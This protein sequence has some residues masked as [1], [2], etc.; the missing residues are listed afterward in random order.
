MKKLA[1]MLLLGCRMMPGAYQYYLYDNS[2]GPGPW[3][4]I[5]NVT[6][7]PMGLYGG[8]L[9]STVPVPD[10]TNEYEVKSELR[11]WY[12]G[13]TYTHYLRANANLTT[14]YSV[15]LTS[16][17]V[18]SVNCTATLNVRKVVNSVVTLLSSSA[19][20]CRDGIAMRSVYTAGQILVYLDNVY[21]GG[22][23]D[24]SIT[25]GQPGVGVTPQFYEFGL[26]ATVYLG[27]LDR[28]APSPV[29]TQ[30]IAASSFATKADVQWAGAIDGANGIGIFGYRIFRDGVYLGER[31]TPAFSDETLSPNTTYTYS[32]YATD[33]HFNQSSAVTFAVTTTPP[34]T[35]DARRVGVRTSGAYWGGLGE[36]IDMASGNLNYSVP[37]LKAMGRGWS[38]PFL[39]SYNSQL[40]RQEGT[41]T[42]KLGQDVGYGFGWRMMA[43]SVMPVY[44][45]YW[46]L[47]HYVFTDA[48][49]AEYRLD[50]NTN[51]V[52]T[53]RDSTYISYDTNL[54]RVYFT[55]GSHWEM[56]AQSA[57]TED[58]AGTRYPTIMQDSNGN[59]VLVRYKTGVNAGWG[60]S[61]AR[62]DEIEDVRATT[63]PFQPIHYKTYTFTYTTEAVPHLTSYMNWIGTSEGS[64]FTYSTVSLASPFNSASFGTTP[65][66]QTMRNTGLNVTTNFEYATGAGELTKVTYP[67]GG[68]QRWEY[69]AFTY[70]GNRSLREVQNRYLL[71]AVGAAE[72]TYQMPRA[73][74]DSGLSAHSAGTV[75]DPSGARKDW[76][77]RTDA[78]GPGQVL[79][80]QERGSTGGSV[81]RQQ[82]FTWTADATGRPYV[83]AVVAALDGVQSKSEQTLDGYG[84]VTVSKQYD[85]GNLTTPSRTYTNTYLTASY[86]TS[87]YM[88]NRLL[89]STVTGAGQTMTLATNT[90][91]GTAIPGGGGAVRQWVSV[92]P[93]YRGNLSRVVKPGSIANVYVNAQGMTPKTTDDSGHEINVSMGYNGAV[94]AAI[95]GG[96]L[97]MSMSYNS[98]LGLTQETGSNGE[99]AAIGYDSVGRPTQTTS[100]TGAGTSIEYTNS[101]PTTK[102]TTNGR[103]TKTTF[104][105]LG[106]AV[107]VESG[108]L[109]GAGSSEVTKSV[110][111][112][113]YDSC[114]CTPV[115]KMKRV[116]QPYAPGGTVYWTTNTYD[117]LGRTTRVDLPGGTGY[118]MY[119]YAGNTVTKTDPAGRW[120]KYTMDAMG[121]LTSVT[122]GIR[123]LRPLPIRGA[124]LPAGGPDPETTYAYN[125]LNK[126]TTV[127]MTRGAVTQ[128]RSFVYNS[129]QRLQT[130]TNPETGTT[131]YEYNA[132]GTVLRKTDAKGQKT[133]YTYDTNQRVVYV[134]RFAAG[135]TVAD[136]CQS[137]L[138]M[139]DTSAPYP[140]Y[141]QNL[142]G[143]VSRVTYPTC[144]GSY[145]LM[146]EMYSYTAAGQMTKK[147]WRWT[148]SHPEHG[149][150][151]VEWEQVAGYDNE[152][153]TVTKGGMGT[154][155]TYGYAYDTMGRE[156]G[157]TLTYWNGDNY[158][159]VDVVKDVLYGPAGEMTQMKRLAGNG[160]Y[161]T[162]TWTYNA[163][164]QMTRQTAVGPS[165][166]YGMPG[167]D[168]EYRYSGTAN[169]G[170]LTQAK[171][172]VTGEDVTYQYD[173]LGRLIAAATTGPEWG[174]SFGYDG[175]G[176]RTSQA[177][178]KGAAPTSYLNYDGNN[179]I[180][181]AGFAYDL[182]GNMTQMPGVTG[183]MTYDA[184]NRLKTAA[185]ET[186][187]YGADNRR[188]LKRTAAGVETPTFW[189]IDG[190]R[191]GELWFA[192]RLLSADDGKMTFTDRVGSV[193]LRV[194]AANAPTVT[195]ERHGYYPYGE[196]KTATAGNR[197]KFGTYTRDAATGLDYADQRYYGSGLGRFTT[198]D[199]YQ[200]SGGPSEPGSWN[201][202]AYVEGD[203]VNFVDPRGLDKCTWNPGTNTLN[204]DLAWGVPDSYIAV[205]G[206]NGWNWSVTGYQNIGNQ[207]DYESGGCMD[208]E[209]GL[210]CYA[211]DKLRRERAQCRAD[212][213]PKNVDWDETIDDA[214]KD[215]E[216]LIAG[217]PS[218]SSTAAGFVV[219][220]GA[221]AQGQRYV[222]ITMDITRRTL[223]HA[224]NGMII[225]EIPG[226]NNLT[227]FA[228]KGVEQVMIQRN[229]LS[230]LLNKINSIA[231]SNPNYKDAMGVGQKILDSLC[232]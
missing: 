91:D 98:F 83:G 97:T 152:G 132:D 197:T 190:H 203:P 108:D 139:Y 228:A 155:S 224:K 88:R 6:A 150:E 94:P 173:A 21:V 196:E 109:S 145:A 202:Y 149:E 136:P 159:T 90:Y 119:E 158:Q 81:L 104:D 49:G 1:V 153:R 211:A 213:N 214:L 127:T 183:T 128:T 114:A 10:G 24:T 227:Y 93:T 137:V 59:Q 167:L 134:N 48:T 147:K 177:V 54:R 64:T 194:Y 138:Y 69:G 232:Q 71:K 185:G 23:Y 146:T 221:N 171:D 201:R 123:R 180:V 76:T 80:F 17:T 172:W 207:A 215:E 86:Y 219:Y 175:F 95:M 161:Y 191:V 18:N 79:S 92:G 198:S 192:G 30:S 160:F 33:F 229:G 125:V 205:P 120:K 200:A 31:L 87:L 170:K 231:V 84:N 102:A 129:D 32:I 29:N 144:G 226:L 169:D 7:G 44:A 28:T 40:W 163:R 168:L 212:A 68:Y 222:G 58:D 165:P 179:R 96:G 182:N 107:K 209:T 60:N 34:S 148:R 186:Y 35:F 50:V 53:S 42:W 70:T 135:S 189:G 19:V 110:V 199:P 3:T 73:S 89:T 216:V 174:M 143:R 113:E 162:E 72:T 62:I 11:I 51:G 66:L 121:N 14:Y 105:G 157:M 111:E 37:L 151:F 63:A 230:N 56:G 141:G 100:A 55:D 176:N 2:F 164:L 117:G 181:G 85:Y 122:E 38:V 16:V 210:A 61:S 41:Q 77:F 65:V 195:W 106:R 130:V 184:A 166:A 47:H 116:S 103:W 204:C 112:T 4:Y 178:T 46:T 45:N 101:P 67:Y 12:P 57:G 131:A 220:L 133:E 74:G 39:L 9:V 115:G 223:E 142:Q 217:V 126:L 36:Q 78:S 218:L 43:G 27:T 75:I 225:A 187:T 99:T 124:E 188:V 22:S 193:R 154:D 13:G 82:D 156:K 208:P 5:G 8:H 140:Y 118:S 52:W 25:S 15:S 26:M 20:G 206:Q